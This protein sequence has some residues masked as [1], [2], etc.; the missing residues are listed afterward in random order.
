MLIQDNFLN[1]NGLG[2]FA[3]WLG[4]LP[5]GSTPS[6]SLKKKILSILKFLRVES[7]HLQKNSLGKIIND[8]Y[9]NPSKF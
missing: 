1:Q 6:I 3:K 9:K 8:I 5:D 4:K 2:I 7:E